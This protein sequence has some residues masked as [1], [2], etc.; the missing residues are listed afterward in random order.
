V[1]LPLSPPPFLSLTL[2]KII[3]SFLPI[4]LDKS[5]ILAIILLQ[6]R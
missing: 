1:P 2:S 5:N 3:Y 6:A 4:L